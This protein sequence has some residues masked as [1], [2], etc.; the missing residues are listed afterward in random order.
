MAM[1]VPEGVAGLFDAGDF[2]AGDFYRGAGGIF[3]GTG[4]ELD[5]GYGG[6]AWEGFSAEAEGGDFE[7]V[8]RGAELGGGVALEG[9]EG[10][11]ADH[12]VAVIDDA[13]ELAAARFDFNADAGGAGV[14]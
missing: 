13:D 8:I 9:E 4:F 3:R 7:K 11:V 14:E 10:V 6:D 2:A 1:V 12:A 5:S